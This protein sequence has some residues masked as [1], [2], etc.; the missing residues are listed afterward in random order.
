MFAFG[1]PTSRGHAALRGLVAAALGIACL[2]WPGITIGVAV[3]LFA[4]YCF[5][6][7]I[8]QVVRLFRADDTA[9]Q[10]VLMILLGLLDVAAG[11]VAIAYPGI[12]AGAL[13]IVIGIWAIVGGGAELAAAWSLRGSGSGWFTVGGLLSIIAG[14]LLIVWPGIGAVSLAVVFGV[15]LVA[16]GITMLVSAAVAPSGSEVGAVA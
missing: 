4:I 7:A 6:D 1:A 16:Y 9:G 2:V 15:Y 10:R 5:A 14:V 3:A 8:T 11:L 13:V 12:T